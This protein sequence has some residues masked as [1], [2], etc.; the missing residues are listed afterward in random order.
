M[1]RTQNTVRPALSHLRSLTLLLVAAVSGSALAQEPKT[2]FNI[3][4]PAVFGGKNYNPF[5][6]GAQHLQPT[7]SAI[8]ESLFYVNQLD[9]KVTSV[10]GTKYAWGAGNK[11]LTLT[12]RSGVKWSDG[13]PFSAADVAFTFNYLK[14][15]P[16]LDLG[17]LWKNGIDT[18]R[19]TNANT[20]VVTFSKV[21]VPLF[22]ALVQTLIVPEHLWSAVK[23]PVTFNNENPVG[24]G[25]FLAESYSQQAVR[26]LKNPNYWMKGQTLRGRGGLVLDLRQRRLA[27]QDAQGRDRLRLHR[28]S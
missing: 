16:G 15:N 8:Y 18:V 5:T 3:V 12:T 14:A 13:K 6:P 4:V 23:D 22:A 19:A 26:V 9:G 1:Q 24:T 7:Q 10:L 27:A 2:T 21:N 11:T 20:V 17:G 25:P 28:H